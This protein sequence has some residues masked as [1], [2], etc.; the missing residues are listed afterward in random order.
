MEKRFVEWIQGHNTS[1]SKPGVFSVQDAMKANSILEGIYQKKGRLVDGWNLYV[2]SNLGPIFGGQYQTTQQ[3]MLFASVGS[4]DYQVALLSHELGHSLSLPHASEDL[5]DNLMLKDGPLYPEVCN[6]MT[7]KQID[8][9]RNQAALGR[10]FSVEDRVRRSFTRRDLNRDGV[11]SRDEFSMSA[12]ENGDGVVELFEFEK[13]QPRRVPK[14]F[15]EIDK[16]RD[17]FAM[18]EE[19][20][21]FLLRAADANGDRKLDAGE[22]EQFLKRRTITRP[23]VQ[24]AAQA[25]KLLGQRLLGIGMKPTGGK[26]DGVIVTRT[27]KGSRGAAAGIKVGDRI[28]KIDGKATDSIPMFRAAVREGGKKQ[29]VEVQRDGEALEFTIEFDR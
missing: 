9:A 24:D 19:I 6:R 15:L 4:L 20:P 10:P 26:G 25:E 12:D 5:T 21:I 13:N 7:E 18:E 1:R 11:L 3:S 8:A 29:V 14:T 28:L 27:L 23:Q 22:F 2:V 17:G 16:N